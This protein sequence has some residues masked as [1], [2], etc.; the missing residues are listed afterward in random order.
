MRDF[1]GD[2]REAKAGDSN[3]RVDWKGERDMRTERKESRDHR[4]GESRGEG[5]EGRRGGEGRESS[6]G[7][8]LSESRGLNSDDI[9]MS[10]Q[11][12]G[13]V[14]ESWGSRS[15]LKTSR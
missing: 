12:A 14:R 7:A 5:R 3:Y 6:R 8:G 2:G 15:F 13:E 10:M 4:G 11:E 1:R 9:R